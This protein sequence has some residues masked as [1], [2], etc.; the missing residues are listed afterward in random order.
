[1]LDEVSEGDR[2]ASRWVMRGPNRGR[3]A[4]ITEITISRLDG[5]RIVE[6]WTALDGLEL[7]RQ[8]GFVRTL[9]AAPRLLHA[10]RAVPHRRPR[11]S[12]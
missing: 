10:M 6:D 4:E 7:L 1:M 12:R 11:M 8:V 9:S 3:S 2:V 5:G